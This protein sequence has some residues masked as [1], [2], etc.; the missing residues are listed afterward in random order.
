MANG[1]IAYH[2]ES[3]IEHAY[4]ILEYHRFT[5]RDI[6]KYMPF[7]EQSLIFFDEHYRA[8][9]ELRNGKEL[10]ENGKLVIYPSTS[11]ESYRG[12]TNPADV[13]AG[14]KACLTSL[15]ELDEKYLSSDAGQNA[16]AK[17]L[18]EG[19]VRFKMIYESQ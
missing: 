7:I 9:Q 19:F 18:F 1:A 2:W 15:I 14:L 12:A 13:L 17:G 4:M 5:G 3:Q 16:V 10:D 11:C 6:S 8:R